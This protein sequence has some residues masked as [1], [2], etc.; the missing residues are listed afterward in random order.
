VMAKAEFVK[1]LTEVP[2]HAASLNNLA[3]ILWRQNY[4]AGAAAKYAL[5]MEASPE[6]QLLLDNVA[7]ALHAM[8]QESVDA[9]PVRLAL[10]LFLEQ[11]ALLQKRLAA[12][13]QYRW[14]STWVTAAELAKLKPAEQE[15]NDQLASLQTDIDS[16]QSSLDTENTEMANTRQLMGVFEAQATTRGERVGA[17]TLPIVSQTYLNLQQNLQQLQTSAAADEDRL[18]QLNEQ[19]VRVRQSLPVQ[20]YS[21]LQSLMGVEDAPLRETLAL[22]QRS[23]Q[24]LSEQEQQQLPATTEP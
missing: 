13:D 12:Q 9:T 10:R 2:D 17:P 22:P 16:T 24:A 1:V 7:E 5:A 4:P 19:A 18:N 14:G 11:D 8:P 15:M 20:R 21:G 23:R 6:N 3:I